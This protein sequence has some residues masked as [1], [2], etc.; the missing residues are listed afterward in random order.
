MKL[1]D[2]YW[3][4]VPY[5][6]DPAASKKRPVIIAKDN[7][8]VYVLTFKM[9]S[10]EPRENDLGD[11]ALKYWKESGL[12]EPSTVRL[13]KISQITPD[14]IGDYIGRVHAVDAFR[15]QQTIGEI[16]KRRQK[17]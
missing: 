5:E 13:M 6:D 7:S 12:E 2:I 17:G 9:T 4:D 1:W 14:R 11:Y 3:A 10:K 15:I 8:P 16:K